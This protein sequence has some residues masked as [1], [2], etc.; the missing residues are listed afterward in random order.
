[1]DNLEKGVNKSFKNLLTGAVLS[2]IPREVREVFNYNS[3][4]YN[5]TNK[6]G[7]GIDIAKTILGTFISYKLFGS[8]STSCITAYLLSAINFIKFN[9][10][11]GAYEDSVENF[12]AKKSYLGSLPLELIYKGSNYYF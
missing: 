5:L 12:G 3:K 4:D 10:S 2:Q 7:I 6:M 1:M 9:E 11:K 8:I